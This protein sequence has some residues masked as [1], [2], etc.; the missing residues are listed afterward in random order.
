MGIIPFII[1]AFFLWKGQMRFANGF[2]W[3]KQKVVGRIIGALLI[4]PLFIEIYLYIS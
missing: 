3:P 4:I 1:G 2:I